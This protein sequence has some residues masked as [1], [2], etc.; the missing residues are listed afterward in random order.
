M[1][2][3]GSIEPLDNHKACSGI[4]IIFVPRSGRNVGS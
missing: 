1:G 4:L 3:C 2:I